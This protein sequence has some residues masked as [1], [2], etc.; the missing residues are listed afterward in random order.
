LTAPTRLCS[1]S[2]ALL[3]GLEQEAPERAHELRH[4]LES[5]PAARSRSMP[6]PP[7]AF[8]RK[9][10]ERQVTDEDIEVIRAAGDGYALGWPPSRGAGAACLAL[11]EERAWELAEA[12]TGAHRAESFADLAKYVSPAKQHQAVVA[13]M[14]AYF[15]HGD[16]GSRPW[17]FSCAAWMSRTDAALLMGLTL[18]RDPEADLERTFIGP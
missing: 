15:D 5:G 14:D 18:G 6:E 13:A 7:K 12:T 17:S 4:L 8:W 9:V 11:G 10:C 1:L 2:A 3:L 16:S